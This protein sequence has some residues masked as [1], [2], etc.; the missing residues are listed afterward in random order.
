MRLGSVSLTL[1][2]RP[3]TTGPGRSTSPRG[4]GDGGETAAIATTL[5][6]ALGVMAVPRIGS[7]VASFVGLSEVLFALGFAWIFL[8]EVP[9]PIQFAG[10][11]LIL[12]GVILVRADAQSTGNPRG[13]AATVPMVPAP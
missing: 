1:P 12:V 3:G 2:A 10:G 4:R 11:A 5:G 9:A 8:A 6:Y 7:R 13:E